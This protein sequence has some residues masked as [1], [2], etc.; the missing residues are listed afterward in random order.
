MKVNYR[1]KNLIRKYS[2]YFKVIEKGK[3]SYDTNTG[4]YIDGEE[5]VT[6]IKGCVVPY[7]ENVIYQ[8]GGNILQTDRQIIC[9]RQIDLK[10]TI[11]YK[12][13]KYKVLQETPYDEY[14]DFFIYQARRVDSF[15]KT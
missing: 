6:A 1:F 9:L 2:T 7:S 15:D 4:K 3:G 10:A 5:T 14:G 13:K 8:S 12:N 11:I